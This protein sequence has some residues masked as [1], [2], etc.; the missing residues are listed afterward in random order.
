MC[1]LE[2]FS[3][4]VESVNNS[5]GTDLQL[6][7]STRTHPVPNRY[8]TVGGSR[9]LWMGVFFGP[10]WFHF[11]SA[12]LPPRNSQEQNRRGGGGGEGDFFHY[13]ISPPG[14]R[15]WKDNISKKRGHQSD[16]TV[17]KSATERQWILSGEQLI[18]CFRE[19]SVFV[20]SRYSKTMQ[21]WKFENSDGQMSRYSQ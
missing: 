5:A 16:K 14:D 2:K 21:T 4:K 19:E 17:F 12:P 8:L 18:T 20:D 10:L 1:S 7:F 3:N 11:P 9:A 15:V 6:F 13:H